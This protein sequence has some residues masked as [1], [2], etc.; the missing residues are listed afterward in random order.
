MA[1]VSVDPGIRKEDWAERRH[2]GVGV[3]YKGNQITC[4]KMTL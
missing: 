1:F 2:T 3:I 4:V